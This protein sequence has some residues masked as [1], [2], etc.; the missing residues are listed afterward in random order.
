M[1]RSKF[2]AAALCAAGLPAALLAGVPASSRGTAEPPRPYDVAGG[3]LDLAPDSRLL[4]HLEIIGVG[5][6]AAESR[7]YRAVGQIIALS[8]ASGS[9][10]GERSGWVE[11]DPALSASIGLELDGRAGTAYGLT[12]L[13]AE[14]A[15]S[16]RPGQRLEISRYGLKDARV[17]GR[18]VRVVPS[19]AGGD[20][21]DVVF[22]FERA[23]DWF[24]GTSCEVSFP[25]LAG[26]PVRIP[27]TAPVHEGASEYVWKES[28]PGRFEARSV[29]FVDS[30]PDEVAVLGLEPGDRIVASGAILLKPLL[31]RVLARGRD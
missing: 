12:T 25:V 7:E 30:T 27:T 8:N 26:R 18:V 9:L 31:R 4:A 23:Q 22:R 17:P 16:L 29:S 11:L 13:P 1:N 2:A 21:A 3:R 5:K 24:P 19:R 10:A 20:R 14:S 28:S 6:A 15:A